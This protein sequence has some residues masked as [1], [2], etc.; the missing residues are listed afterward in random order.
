MM[1]Q[2]S[3]SACGMLLLGL[4]AAPPSFAQSAPDAL[5]VRFAPGCS[6]APG[7]DDTDP[8]APARRASPTAADRP[9]APRARA[10]AVVLPEN[11][12]DRLPYLA[13]L[14]IAPLTAMGAEW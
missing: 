3:R 2:S 11:V 8:S 5:I 12:G 6:G 10:I 4:I 13:G 7:S 14:A 9:E 1:S